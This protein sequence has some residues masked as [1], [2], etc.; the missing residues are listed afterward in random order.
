MILCP[1]LLFTLLIPSISPS[2]L[3]LP[4]AHHHE[5]LSLPLRGDAV[6][7]PHRLILV[8]DV[9]H[10]VNKS[11]RSICNQI[12]SAFESGSFSSECP[13]RISAA[14]RAA[15]GLSVQHDIAFA[16]GVASL[17]SY[18]GEEGHGDSDWS[19]FSEVWQRPYKAQFLQGAVARA[20]TAKSKV[21]IN[22]CSV[23]FGSGH[24]ALLLL[25][26]G[27]ALGGEVRVYSFDRATAR[28]AIP[29]QDFLDIRY[30][31][32]NFLF[33]GDP[34]LAMSRFKFAFPDTL[35]DILLVDPNGLQPLMGN[36]S[37]QA[38]RSLATLA[39]PD[40]LL[41]LVTTNPRVIPSNNDAHAGDEAPVSPP[42][43]PPSEV[44]A[45]AEAAGWIDWEG[46]L[47]QA[48]ERPHGDSLLYGKFSSQGP[49]PGLLP[50]ERF[51]E[52]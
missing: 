23:G 17:E 15:R 34:P 14:L 31:E 10:T 50:V 18:L 9:D 40:S 41:V 38:L 3:P 4:R 25:T 6:A 49:T 11:A 45:Q 52:V 20:L 19:G 32:R 30:P 46:T 24:T 44:W 35:C 39:A 2:L 36:A 27:E 48:I 22:V 51:Y 28:S 8:A 37:A 33:L 5:S 7:L 13:G 43:L 21:T 47:L 16:S 1:F 42:S 12:L 26:A 29:A